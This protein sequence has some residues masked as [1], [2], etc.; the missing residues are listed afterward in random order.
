MKYKKIITLLLGAFLAAV[1][2]ARAQSMRITPPPPPAGSGLT[3]VGNTIIP[4]PGMSLGDFSN[5]FSDIWVEGSSIHLGDLELHEDSEDQGL[6]VGNRLH[7]KTE[8]GV[9]GSSCFHPGTV[10]IVNVDGYRLWADSS[11]NIWMLLPNAD[12][13]VKVNHQFLTII[14]AIASI[15]GNNASLKLE[16]NSGNYAIIKAG[17][18]QLTFEADP[19]NAVPSTDIVFKMDGA[20]VGRFQQGGNFLITEIR[21]RD[22]AGLGLFDDAG[23]GIFVKD[24]GNFGIGT[25]TPGSPLEVNGDIHT[26]GTT[27]K[28]YFGT[29]T[30]NE[31]NR[32]Y[33]GNQASIGMTLDARHATGGL[34]F[35]TNDIERMVINGNGDIDMAS[36]LT[37]LNGG[38]KV[39][40]TGSEPYISF[41]NGNDQVGLITAG[42]DS[43]NITNPAGSVTWFK[44]D[45][46][47]GETFCYDDLWASKDIHVS[48]DSYLSGD[49]KTGATFNINDG[50]NNRLLISSSSASLTYGNDTYW[51]VSSN[52]INGAVN[53]HTKIL[54]SNSAGTY[55]K[56]EKSAAG[57]SLTLKNSEL[58]Y[59][60]GVRGRL[61]IPSS[62]ATQLVSP[63]GGGYIW[64]Y[65]TQIYLTGQFNATGV[66][67][68]T[69]ASATNVNVDSNGWLKRSTS[70]RKIKFH[71]DY[72][73]VDPSL[74]LQFKPAS[75]NSKADEGNPSCFGFI[76]EDMRDIDPRFATDGGKDDLPGL[77]LN[78]M[79]AAITATVQA[80]QKQIDELKTRIEKSERNHPPKM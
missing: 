17:N 30:I 28:F 79:V 57:G 3:T 58:F 10:P 1:P 38:I 26:T 11:G 72:D 22:G 71:I 6:E 48:G 24:G 27:D 4:D 19:D 13:Q 21:A 74:A 53:G 29:G 14:D 69:T 34:H 5:R 47:S 52:Q 76:A 59:H 45:T 66:Y 63:G 60:D 12:P 67:N 51:S 7:L 32:G 61:T 18:S 78:A 8:S 39:E 65:D 35:K 64:I 62:G 41:K 37:I 9:A 68:N 43:I 54:S 31:F 36:L 55:L 15:V 56:D 50:T 77:D 80:Q 46:G 49:L 20:E 23:N 42:S 70:S 40:R 44:V 75:F 73:G 16:D 33:W 25:T 2:L